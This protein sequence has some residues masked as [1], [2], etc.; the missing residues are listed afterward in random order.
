MIYVPNLNHKCYVV[1]SQEVIRGYDE[2][3]RSNSTIKY[4]DY[5]FNA[6][7]IYRDGT[8]SFN[9]YSTLPTCIASSELTTDFYYRND[10]ADILLIFTIMALFGIY[11]PL[12][13]FK[14]FI[15]RW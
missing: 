5:Y 14:R 8:Q 10:I 15:R 4:R 7:Y 6:N 11:I 13:L 1:Q 12:K 9:N 2:I 3:P